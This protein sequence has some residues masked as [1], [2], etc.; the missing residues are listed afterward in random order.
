MTP[1]QIEARNA[2]LAKARETA[3][4]NRARK[5]VEPAAEE[6]AVAMPSIVHE[7]AADEPDFDK[8][9]EQI[10]PE[11]D[12]FTRFLMA[13]DAETRE[14]LTDIEL[15]VIYEQEA[16]RAAEE[17][18]AAAKK[19][20]LARAQRHA[21][22]VAG[23]IPAEQAAIAARLEYLSQKVRWTVNMPEAG[24]S[25]M[26][27]DAGVRIDGTLLYHGQRVEGTRA[28]YE[29][30]REIEWRAHQNEL[31]FQGKSRL[32]RLRRTAIQDLN[33]NGARL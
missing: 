15:R 27:V 13:Q 22:M 11:A 5:A 21:R 9:A 31:D 29:S 16:K 24:N 8:P 3:A 20:A 14:L 30:Y 26:L 28:Q 23:L 6:P 10:E 12:D 1:E 4:A 2:R 32:S 25:G 17:K 33:N 7:G 19:G 18:K